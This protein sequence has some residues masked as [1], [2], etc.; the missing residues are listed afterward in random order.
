MTVLRDAKRRY[1]EGIW[2]VLFFVLQRLFGPETFSQFIE[3]WFA[4]HDGLFRSHGVLLDL[5]AGHVP[6]TTKARVL[7]RIY[8]MEERWFVERYI[9]ERSDVVELGAGVGFISCY[10]RSRLADESTYVAVE[11]VADVI[12]IIERNRELNGLEFSIVERAYSSD[13]GPIAIT[14][15][16]RFTASGRYRTDGNE[17]TVETTDLESLVERFDLHRFDLIADI[18]GAE[19]ELLGTELDILESRCRTMVIELHDVRDGAIETARAI[20]DRSCFEYEAGLNDVLV[21]RN[22][23]V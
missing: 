10:A 11:P 20:L 2:S 19:L 4:R 15:P 22:P 14:V 5:S 17:R 8:E 7:L 16:D 1:E 23:T 6:S 3:Y 21:Y 13:D 12:P 18:E 9:D